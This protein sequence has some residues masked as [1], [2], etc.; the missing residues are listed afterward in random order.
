MRLKIGEFAKLGHVSIRMLR[1]YDKLGLLHPEYVGSDTGYRYYTI[2]QLQLLH[3]IQDLQT[4]GFSLKQI[5]EIVLIDDVEILHEQLCIQQQI[6]QSQL[7]EQQR[8]LKHL[9]SRIQRVETDNTLRNIHFVL[10][11]LSPEKIVSLRSPLNAEDDIQ[12]GFHKLQNCLNELKIPIAKTMGIKHYSYHEAAD[13][14]WAFQ[15]PDMNFSCIDVGN[16]A[17]LLTRHLPTVQVASAVI[18]GSYEQSLPS[19]NGFWEW[20][21]AHHYELIG[22]VREIYLRIVDND[23]HHPDNL[24]EVQFPIGIA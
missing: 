15:F 2:D 19:H 18:R 16:E 21:S 3:R 9:Q 17:K 13:F 8:Q 23:I 11:T 1:H 12:N 14:E 4:M 6:L 10:K 22:S 20:A 5:K 24:M 7:E